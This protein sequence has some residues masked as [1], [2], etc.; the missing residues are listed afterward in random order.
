MSSAPLKKKKGM[1]EYK[2]T[3]IETTIKI[4]ENQRPTGHSDNRCHHIH[5]AIIMLNIFKDTNKISGENCWL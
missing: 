2:I 4:K 5:L 1:W 3:K